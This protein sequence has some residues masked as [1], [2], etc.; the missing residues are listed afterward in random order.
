M[1]SPQRKKGRCPKLDT[2]WVGP[3]QILERLGEVVDRVQLP[4]R[5]GKV[6]LHWDRLSPY[7]EMASPERQGGGT[8]GMENMALVH[9]QPPSD[10]QSLLHWPPQIEL[11]SLFPNSSTQPYLPAP[12]LARV[13]GLSRSE[14]GDYV[15]CRSLCDTGNVK[16]VTEFS[17]I[18]VT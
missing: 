9:Q 5:G 13:L 4:P 7:R 1:Y 18:S 12:A 2:E 16:A 11:F 15:M 6:A 3:C 17:L 14:R 8:Q 10:K